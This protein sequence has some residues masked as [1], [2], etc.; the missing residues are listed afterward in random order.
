MTN[1]APT[2]SPLAGDPRFSGLLDAAHALQPKTV[3][4]RRQLHQHPE[5]G[6]ELPL[7]QAAVLSALEGLDLRVHTGQKVGSVIGVLEGARPGPTVL[8]RGDMDALPLQEDTGLAFASQTEGTMHACGHDTHVAMLASAARLLAERRDQLAGTV[9][10]MFQPGEE[11]HYGA[12]FMLDEGL[13]D[14]AD[15]PVDK[16]LALH[17]TSKETSGVLR[18]RPGPIMASANSFTIRI[19]GKGGHA[20]NPSDAVDPVVAAAAMVGALQT[21][22]TRRI[23][24]FEPTVLTI[25]RISAGTTSNIIPETAEL[26]GTLRT[27]SEA[28]RAT[29]LAEIPRV[30]AQIAAAHGCTTTFE[31]DAGYPVTVNDD[32]VADRVHDIARATLGSM[33]VNPMTNPLMGAEDWSYVLQRVPGAMAFL[34]ACPPGVDP[35]EA[36][37]NH[38][39]RVHFDESA[40]PHGVSTYA[41]FAL[42]MLR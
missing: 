14:V 34:G 7:T 32:E 40:L 3:A 26:E 10:F 13:L 35:D 12:K 29:M 20:S 5:Q 38:S 16:A 42:D 6:L 8:L 36:A 30:C 25:A 1:Q 17:I 9:V 2:A 22:V 15:R 37:P 27:L 19:T 31:V 18:S 39:N 41:A 24:V 4:L 21:V 28:S 33:H 11:G 23:S